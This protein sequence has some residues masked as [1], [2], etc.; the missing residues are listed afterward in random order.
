MWQKIFFL[1]SLVFFMVMNVLLWRSYYGQKDLALPIPVEVVT[2][3]MFSATDD[4]NL[5][6]L[7]HGAKVG[8]CR[9]S[10]Q[11]ISQVAAP[12]SPGSALPEGMIGTITAYSISFDGTI[13]FGDIERVRFNFSME[14][15]TNF[16]WRSVQAR[17]ATPDSRVE[18][19]STAGDDS[20][21]LTLT[22]GNQ[23]R[24]QVFTLAELQNPRTLLRGLGGGVLAQALGVAGFAF[25]RAQTGGFSLGLD[26][27]AHTDRQRMGNTSFPVYRLQT[28]VLGDYAFRAVVLPS[29]ELLRVELPDEIVLVNDKLTSM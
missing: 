11:T 12:A 18:A 25:P 17:L 24:Q 8:Y 14:L 20:V 26:W 16:V 15:D 28:A 4:S 1:A 23:V 19:T 29:G 3:R 13:A 10:P 5:D 27:E 6:I 2:R 9:W 22:Q 21:H 7:H